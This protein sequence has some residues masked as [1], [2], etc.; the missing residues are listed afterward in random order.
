MPTLPQLPRE[1]VQWL[2]RPCHLNDHASAT[3]P[4]PCWGERRIGCV[5]LAVSGKLEWL[6]SA[7]RRGEKSGGGGDYAITRKIRICENVRKIC[8]KMRKICENYAVI[9]SFQKLNQV[10]YFSLMVVIFP[11]VPISAPV[12]P[13]RAAQLSK[14]PQAESRQ[15]FP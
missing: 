12:G 6:C 10:F 2:R 9:C 4:L 3:Y 14:R 5:A 1:Q 13:W 15:L 11:S 7:Y 8:D